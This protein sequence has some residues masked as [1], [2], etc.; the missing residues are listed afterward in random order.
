M[1]ST[2]SGA[3]QTLSV[4][5][6]AIDG[7]DTGFSGLTLNQATRNYTTSSKGLT[8][9]EDG[10]HRVNSASFTCN[11]TR[12]TNQA[13]LGQNGAR[14]SCTWNDGSDDHTFDAIL[15]ITHNGVA[16]AQRTYAVDL[17]IDGAIT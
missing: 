6:T 17:M 10:G 7:E 5:G 3:K 15:R 14:K 8:S 1:A 11:E 16:R 13:L 9:I 2:K 12:I 4:G